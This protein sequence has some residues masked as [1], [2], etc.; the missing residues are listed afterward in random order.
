MPGGSLR[1]D[2]DTPARRASAGSQV[3]RSLVFMENSDRDIRIRDFE[4]ILGVTTPEMVAQEYAPLRWH[5]VR[6]MAANGISFG[7]HTVTH[8]TLSAVAERVR[9]DQELR[10]SE[11]RV[12]DETNR[13][14]P[15]FCYPSGRDVDITDVVVEMV[16]QYGYQAAVQTEPGLNRRD[17]DLMR[18]RRM[19]TDPDYDG[20]YFERICAVMRP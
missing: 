17:T 15:V 1:F 2:L 6:E 9:I 14:A 10:F 16:H 11:R 13:E 19:G 3:A 12:E 4:L 5:D 20:L 7:S 18:L 8:P